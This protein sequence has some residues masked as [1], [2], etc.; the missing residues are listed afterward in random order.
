[1]DIGKYECGSCG[2]SSAGTARQRPYD[3]GYDGG[4]RDS[5][6]VFWVC[7]TVAMAVGRSTGSRA[8]GAGTSLCS[9]S[10]SAGGAARLDRGEL[11]YGF[12]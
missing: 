8:A 1:M 5:E 9:C 3:V 2:T 6:N 4:S 12:G 10:P 11:L 7:A